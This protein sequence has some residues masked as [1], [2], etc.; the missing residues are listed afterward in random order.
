[1]LRLALATYVDPGETVVIAPPTYSLYKVLIALHGARTVEVPLTEDWRVPAGFAASLNRSGARLAF[2]VN[3]HAPSGRLYD[4]EEITA[5][6]AGFEGVLLVD[7]AYVDF[8]DPTHGYDLVPAI[9]AHP[10]LLILRT[11]S[12]GY[13]LA[14]LRFGY[15]LGSGPLLEPMLT[16]TKDSYNVDALAVEVARAAIESREWATDNWARVR[17]ER[18]RLHAGLERLGLPTLPS[19]TN[20]VLASVPPDV[21]AG[22]PGHRDGGESTAA[23]ALYRALKD[24]DVHVRWFGEPR[25]ADRLRI[26]VGAREE[27]DRLLAVLA[28]LLPAS[29]GL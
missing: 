4:R 27:N 7:E 24:R 1:M 11:L 5:V 25:L 29:P 26:S 20:F 16:K 21:L 17:S 3:P 22:H 13:S 15:G 28:D 23:N 2:L 10:N 12:K 9:G 14:G 6:A 19:E 8:V 18:E